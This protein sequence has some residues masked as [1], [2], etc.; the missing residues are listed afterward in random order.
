MRREI[1][2]DGAS[3][4]VVGIKVSLRV[5]RNASVLGEAVKRADG[6]WDAA[7]DVC[8]LTPGAARRLGLASRV[9]GD[10]GQ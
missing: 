4:T 9:K 10:G 1:V 6:R 7:A 8:R 2:V 5:A 3:L